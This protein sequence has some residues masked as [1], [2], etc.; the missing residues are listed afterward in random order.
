MQP[1]LSSVTLRNTGFEAEALPWLDAVYRFALR[2]TGGIEA[3]AEDLTQETFLRAF[4]SWDTFESGT[5]A[6]SWLFTICRNVFLRQQQLK[7]RLPESTNSELDTDLGAIAAH[8]VF[9]DTAFDPEQR[10]FESLVDEEVIRALD[11]L[12]TEFRE[13]VALSDVEGLGYNEIAEVLGVPKGT[14][15]SRIFRGRRLLQQLLRAYALEMG[16]IRRPRA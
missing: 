4:R 11:T 1:D 7:A 10:F 2:L 15:K 6:R 8:D 3:E 13:A 14:V 16:Y 5:N 9:H 12:P